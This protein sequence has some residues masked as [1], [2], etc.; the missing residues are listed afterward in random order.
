MKRIWSTLVVV[1]FL[2]AVVVYQAQG[3]PVNEGHAVFLPMASQA[4]GSVVNDGGFESGT[5]AQWT[6]SGAS[7]SAQ[8]AHS[9]GYG[10]ALNG[11]G[12]RVAQNIAS[13]LTAGVTYNFSAWVRVTKRGTSWGSVWF[14]LDK[15]ADCG[16]G[17]FGTAQ[18][19][20]NTAPGW[21]QLTLKASFT[22]SQL[23]GPVYMCLVGFGFS[24]GTANVDDI[25]SDGTAPTA[26]ATPTATFTRTPAATLTRT[27]TPTPTSTRTPTSTPTAVAP[28][29]TPTA[30]RTPTNTPTPSQTSTP[31]TITPPPSG[32]AEWAQFGANAQRTSYVPQDITNWA[33]RCVWNGQ[34]AST[35]VNTQ[36]VEPVAGDGKIFVSAGA[37]GVYAI[38]DA[39]CAHVWNV[40]I[41]TNST[42]A[43]DSGYVYVVATNGALYKLNSS[44][45]AVVASVSMGTGSTNPLPPLVLSDR[46]IFTAGN[47][48]YAVSKGTLQ[49]IWQYNAGARIDTPASYSSR[50][51]VVI[52]TQDL[53]VHAV[54]NASGTLLWRTKPT[55]RI[56]GTVGPNDDATHAEVAL[57]YPAI[58]DVHGIV[59][60]RYKIDWGSIYANGE[61]QPDNTWIRNTLTANPVRQNVFALSLNDGSQ[62]FVVNVGEGGH[63]YSSIYI[64]QGRSPVVKVLPNG[65]EVAYLMCRGNTQ[66]DA[67]WDSHFCELM[68]DSNTVPGY[69]AGYVRY[70]SY[71]SPPGSGVNQYMITDEQPYVVGAGITL[72][73]AHWQAGQTVRITNRGDT[74]GSLAS[75]IQ[76]QND[77]TVVERESPPGYAACTQNNATHSCGTGQLF[78]SESGSGRLYTP[79]FWVYWGDTTPSGGTGA[80]IVTKNLVIY[81]AFS[82]AV[83]VLA[84][85][86]TG[87]APTAT[88]VSPTSTPT[89]V[90]PT[91]TPAPTNTPSAPSPTP[92]SSGS[93]SSYK[94]VCTQLGRSV[95]ELGS[96][97]AVVESISGGLAVAILLL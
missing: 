18:A 4:Q 86:T 23:S 69:L 46:V 95:Q 64:D 60:V 73:G 39:N 78:Y 94:S 37:S 20:N 51:V 58:A 79:G 17:A 49:T 74:Y 81:K 72:L 54:S 43:Y 6:T 9:G 68:L 63:E 34:D 14:R 93:D 24:N 62:A 87:V 3:S 75:P 5:L 67:R 10:V 13:R 31:V 56:G 66:Y 36:G 96:C 42:V 82:G 25:S 2:S 28:T 88:P 44:T 89:S 77:P 19:A 8:A 26:T 90:P 11:N 29:S 22:A 16:T 47:V 15:Y 85:Q 97:D 50:N 53:Y 70:I 59:F 21:Q 35:H 57:G 30:T 76:S 91:R 65:Q 32:L 38:N 45:G 12:A 80:F 40:A 55:P 84:G 92:V 52:V 1:V 27:S 48:L 41:T 7:V 61:W 33:F 83:I 71:D